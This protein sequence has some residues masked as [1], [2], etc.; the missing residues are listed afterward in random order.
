MARSNAPHQTLGY[1]AG[2]WSFGFLCYCTSANLAY[3]GNAN[4]RASCR[5][6]AK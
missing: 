2:L 4:R 1:V 5:N 6:C 3:K